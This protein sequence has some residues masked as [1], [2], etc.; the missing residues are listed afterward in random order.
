MQNFIL[1]AINVMLLILGHTGDGLN[2]YAE[3]HFTF[4]KCYVISSSHF[5]CGT[6]IFRVLRQVLSSMIVPVEHNV[7]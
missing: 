6:L 4:N 7:M 5:V 3:F 2:Y 1:L